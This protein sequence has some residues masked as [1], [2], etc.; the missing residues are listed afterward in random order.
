MVAISRGP[1]YRK[2]NTKTG[3]GA[4]NGLAISQASLILTTSYALASIDPKN[5]VNRTDREKTARPIENSTTV[6]EFTRGGL[7]V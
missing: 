3:L 1:H 5:R 7:S 6:P 4:K 2:F